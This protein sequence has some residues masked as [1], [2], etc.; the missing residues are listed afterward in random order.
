MRI[1]YTRI[2]IFEFFE[3]VNKLIPM[4]RKKLAMTDEA[5]QMVASRFRALADPTRLR[6]LNLLMG[7]ERAVGELAEAAGIDQPIVSR[8]LAVLRRD[9]IVARRAEGNKGFYRINDATAVQLCE[10]VC[11]GLAEKLADDLEALPDT[12]IWR[13]MNI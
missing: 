9:G 4:A 13:G 11:G 12:A 1:K 5:L 7:G 3:N 10:V 8:Q 2:Y 6:L